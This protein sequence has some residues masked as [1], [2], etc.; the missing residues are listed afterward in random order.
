MDSSAQ[1]GQVP[2][3]GGGGGSSGQAWWHRIPGF[4][5]VGAIRDG[6]DPRCCWRTCQVGTW[7]SVSSRK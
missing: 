4:L 2:D 6:C 5:P 3:G 1:R 7:L